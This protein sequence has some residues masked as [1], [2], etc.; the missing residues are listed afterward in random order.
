[1]CESIDKIVFCTCQDSQTSR[2]IKGYTWQLD[3]LIKSEW[4]G[5]MGS[6]AFP[7][8]DLG[9]EINISNIL[10]VLN[11]PQNL[12]DFKYQPKERDCI[13]ITYEDSKME[14]SYNYFRLR[15]DNGAWIEGGYDIF[16]IVSKELAQG[17][18]KKLSNEEFELMTGR[19]SDKE[20]MFEDIANGSL[21]DMMMKSPEFGRKYSIWERV[22]ILINRI[23]YS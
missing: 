8:E 23:R 9:G 19:I 22:K 4:K 15:F 7:K 21:E 10:L 6:F 2:V 5:I 12:F 1:M 20:F 18:I 14:S 13:T 17:K 3:R 16:T 11:S